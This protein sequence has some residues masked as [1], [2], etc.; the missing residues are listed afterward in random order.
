M[1]CFFVSV[2]RLKNPALNGLP[3]VVAGDPKE[4]RSVVASASYEA[5]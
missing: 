3:M 4:E 2:E 1:D 5:R